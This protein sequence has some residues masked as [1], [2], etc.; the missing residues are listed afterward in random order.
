MRVLET[1]RRKPLWSGA[2]AGV[3]VGAV[4][5]LWRPIQASAPD[6]AELAAWRDYPPAVATRFDEAQFAKVR[7]A[8]LW[9]AERGAGPAAVQ[10]RLAGIIVD[11]APAALVYGDDKGRALRVQVGDTLPDGGKVRAFTGRSVRFERGGCEYDRALYSAIDQPVAA[12]CT[13]R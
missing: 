10:W 6:A 4:A 8:G 11:P 12:G 7:D 9:S 5:G 3:L 13:P 2:L 1:L